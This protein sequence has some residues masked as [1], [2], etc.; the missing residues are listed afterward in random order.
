MNNPSPVEKEKA[1]LPHNT[2]TLVYRKILNVTEFAHEVFLNLPNSISLQ[3]TGWRYD[4]MYFTFYDHEEQKEHILT[5]EKIELGMTKFLQRCL[6]GK[7][8]NPILTDPSTL[9]DTANW[10]CEIIDMAVQTCI[11]D[12]VIYG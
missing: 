12:E 6:E 9:F 10:D 11:F 2:I 3:C 1:P 8:P 5:K 7:W 4:K